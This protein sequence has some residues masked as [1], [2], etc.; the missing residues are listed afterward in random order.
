MNILHPKIILTVSVVIVIFLLISLAQ[1]MNR[2][3]SIQR[4]VRRLEQQVQEMKNSVVE[5][6][7]L[8]QYFRTDE[9]QDR[10]AR[11]K[12]NYRAPGEKVVLIPDPKVAPEEAS[13]KE[14]SDK[15]LSIMERWWR[16]FFVDEAP[17][18]PNPE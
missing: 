10:L 4:E 11:E 16:V 3:L 6:E 14:Q 8:N 18:P 5:A 2:R 13:N 7:N 12:L 15:S 9:Y 17:P 1:E